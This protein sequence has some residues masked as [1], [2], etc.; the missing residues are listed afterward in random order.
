MRSFRSL[1]NATDSWCSHQT[2]SNWLT[3][4]PTYAVYNKNVHPGLTEVNRRKQVE[5]GKHV[6]A[7]WNLPE[8]TKV[9]W[10][11]SDEKWWHG[12]VLRTFAKMSP[13]LGIEIENFTCHR[14]NHI[15]KVM[16]H[17]CD[18]WLLLYWYSREWRGRNLCWPAPMPGVQG[19]T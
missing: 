13:A 19:C 17:I 2:I 1:A 15:G 3:R 9:L 12:L 16:A 10:T 8:G 4:Q 18:G 11:M 5:F 7:F 14:K 6:H